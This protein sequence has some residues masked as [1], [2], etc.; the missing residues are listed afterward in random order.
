MTNQ[1]LE[2]ISTIGNSSCKL[3]ETD[4]STYIPIIA[5]KKL[6]INEDEARALI[7]LISN[8]FKKVCLDSGFNEKSTDALKTKLFAALAISVTDSDKIS[9]ILQSVKIPIITFDSSS[10]GA[11]AYRALALEVSGG[12]PQRTR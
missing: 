5:S 1:I 8:L 2:R 11:K 3:S 9:K 7:R 12:P 6:N 10:A 4:Y